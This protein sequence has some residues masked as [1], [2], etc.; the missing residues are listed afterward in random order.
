MRNTGNLL[1]W[2]Q[3]SNNKS[4]KGGGGELII[5]YVLHNTN[6]F[7]I[8]I[9]FPENRNWIHPPEALQKGHIAYIVKVSTRF[10][11]YFV[12]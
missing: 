1:K 11:N 6:M 4:A 9:F 3:N 7:L 2:T 12:L 5:N 10:S 8:L